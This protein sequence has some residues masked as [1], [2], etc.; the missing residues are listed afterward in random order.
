MVAIPYPYGIR[1]TP[2]EQQLGRMVYYAPSEI[3]GPDAEKR[4]RAE[5]ERAFRAGDDALSQIERRLRALEKVTGI[6]P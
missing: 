4:Q 3:E 6:I 2:P 1:K 5:I